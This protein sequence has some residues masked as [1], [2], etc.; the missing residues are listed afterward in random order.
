MSQRN[1][2]FWSCTCVKVLFTETFLK[3]RNHFRIMPG[4]RS[5]LQGNSD[6]MNKIE[7]NDLIIVYR[8]TDGLEVDCYVLL[9]IKVC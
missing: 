5:A 1:S 7:A 9:F 4:T 8:K 3:S 2:A 6:F